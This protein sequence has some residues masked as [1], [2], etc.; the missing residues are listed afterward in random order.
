MPVILAMWEYRQ[1]DHRVWSRAKQE[2]KDKDTQD[3]FQKPTQNQK[4]LGHDSSRRAPAY[5][6]RER[7]RERERESES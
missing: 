5:H 2:T 1:K 3:P 6:E 7:E 4:G